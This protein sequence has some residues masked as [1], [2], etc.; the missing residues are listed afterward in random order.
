MLKI[1]IPKRELFDDSTNHFIYL[2]GGELVLE[3]SLFAI[4]KWEEKW[5]KPYSSSEKTPEEALDYIRCMIVGDDT[6]TIYRNITKENSQ[7]INEY[8]NNPMTATWFTEHGGKKSGGREIVTAEIIYYWMIVNDIPF[9]CQY[10][11]LNKLMTL[12]R[13]CSE[14]NAPQKKMSKKDI[15]RQQAEINAQRRK[16]LNSKG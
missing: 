2:D 12:I 8:I 10:W 14:K 16:Q 11:H 9:E 15:L 3:H 5:H 1:T 6:T 7:Q 13:V 4:S